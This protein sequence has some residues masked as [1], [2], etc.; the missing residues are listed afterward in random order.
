MLPY[1][2][3]AG[4]R[5]QSERLHRQLRVEGESGGA[6]T[7]VQYQAPTANRDIKRSPHF[8]TATCI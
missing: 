1:D 6:V 4:V 5:S 3:T 7:E 2:R 8:L